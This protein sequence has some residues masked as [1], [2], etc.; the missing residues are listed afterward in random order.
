[1]F[2]HIL[3][4]FPTTAATKGSSALCGFRVSKESRAHCSGHWR[5][6]TAVQSIWTLAFLSNGH[7][8]AHFL[9]MLPGGVVEGM[10]STSQALTVIST[11][12][13]MF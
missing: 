12:A 13:L 5:L 6:S 2:W 10:R 1:M 3:R 9:D 4:G 7:H 11:A 8:V